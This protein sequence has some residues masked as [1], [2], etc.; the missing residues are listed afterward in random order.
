MRI[1]DD[2]APAP[3]YWSFVLGH[4]NLSPVEQ[5]RHW[6]EDSVCLELIRRKDGSIVSISKISEVIMSKCSSLMLWNLQLYN[7][8]FE[9][10]N[11]TF[12]GGSKHTLTPP[13]Y[14]QGVM[15]TNPRIY[16]PV[17]GH[18]FFFPSFPF[19]SSA[20]VVTAK[21][22]LFYWEGAV[23]SDLQVGLRNSLGYLRGSGCT[24]DT[25]CLTWHNHYFVVRNDSCSQL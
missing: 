23:G 24:P 9:W 22:C 25:W 5:Q 3:T 2:G 1:V 8:R 15:T 19:V 12:S 10:K 21:L 11:V 17:T 6:L 4:D 20:G 13:T 7:N 18:G 16:A 14:F